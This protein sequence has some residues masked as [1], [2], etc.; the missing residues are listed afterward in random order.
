MT[1]QELRDKFIRFF[2]DRQHVHAPSASLIPDEETGLLFTT[3][4]MVQFRDYY[5]NPDQAPYARAVTVQKCLRAG[6]KDSDIESVG[7]TARHCTFFEMLGNFSFG[8]YFKDEAVEWGWE[9]VTRVLGLPSD[10]LW[11]SVYEQDDE[12]YQIWDRKIGLPAERIV[13]LSKKDNFWGPAGVSGVCGPCSEIYYDAGESVGCG[14]PGCAPGCDCDRYVEFWNLVFPQFFQEPDGTLRPLER[15]G[16]DTGMGLER[17]AAIMQ[18]VPNIF[19][20]DL[21]KPVVRVVKTMVDDPSPSHRSVAMVSDHARALTFAIADGI[22]PSNEG[23]GYVLRRILR[24]AVRGGH[25]M[26]IDGP[27]LARVVGS[28]IDLMHAAYPELAEQR[29]HIH[30]VVDGEEKRF[31]RTLEFGA[32]MFEEIVTE[33]GKTGTKVISGDQAFRLYDTYGF[34]ID[35]TE[36]MAGERGLSVDRPGFQEAMEAQKNKA[37]DTSRL[38]K[39]RQTV[40]GDWGPASRFVGYETDASEAEVTRILRDGDPVDVAS[41]GE[42]IEVVLS[43]TPF[44]GESG[45]QVGDCGRLE[46][47]GLS[48][49]VTDTQKPTEDHTVHRCRVV[50]GTLRVGTQVLARIDRPRRRAT[51]RHHTSTHLLQA[52]LREVLGVHIKQ[53][54]SLVGPEGFRFD[55]SHPSAVDAVSLAEI[56]RRVNEMIVENTSVEVLIKGVNEAKQLGALAFFGD[57]YGTDARVVKIGEKSLEL[58]GGTHVRAVGEIGA[59]RIVRE[60]SIGAG[61]RR[62]EAVSGAA[63]YEL[64]RRQSDALTEIADLLRG[65][66]E[67]APEKTR[68]ILEARSNLEKKLEE[69]QLHGTGGRLDSLLEQVEMIDG[70]GLLVAR[71][72]GM[73]GGEL[74]KVVDRAKNSIESGV[75]VLASALDRKVVIVVGVTDDLARSKTVHAGAVAKDLSRQLGGNGGGKPTYAQGG[76]QTPEGVD[77]A[78]AKTRASLAGILSGGKQR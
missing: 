50:S 73:D 43:Q 12:A 37:K 35:L 6:G 21:L 69:V 76:G 34:P 51:E 74:G 22:L 4:G 8:D 40:G 75:F 61:L 72:D 64:G 46:A 55:F 25:Q 33:L 9:F 48:V 7:R 10:L 17:L 19:E 15:P 42:D 20:T 44:Y 58:C 36:E 41:P 47:E 28:V 24:R 56:E 5:Q 53:A 11:A 39:A 38:G 78:L 57:K 77:E 3:A 62:I 26:E 30:S 54:G 13:R 32:G 66:W 1:A 65:T 31:L 16:I 59:F 23:R 2:A 71:T 49:E 67:E 27:F 70:H 63:A 18:G 68:Q 60:A 52:A 14:R 29:E 45:G